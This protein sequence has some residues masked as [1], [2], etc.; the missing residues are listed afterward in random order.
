M[1]AATRPDKCKVVIARHTYSEGDNVV[2]AY[3]EPTKPFA[4]RDPIILGALRKLAKDGFHVGIR[5]GHQTLYVL[6]DG[7]VVEDQH[8]TA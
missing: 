5:I 2:I 7:S 8:G 4:Y 1:P 3:V 6:E